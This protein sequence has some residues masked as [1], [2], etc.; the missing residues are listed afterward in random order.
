[1]TELETPTFVARHIG[2]DERQIAAMLEVVG[3]SSLEA[4]IDE[5]A[6]AAIRSARPLDLPPAVSEDRA[7]ATLRGLA[8]D[9]RVLTSMIGMGYYGTLTPSVILRNVVENPGWYTAYTP[10]QAEVSQGRLFLLLK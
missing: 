8:R 6:P 4:L 5:T 10:Y 9:N 1:L 3:A 2:P 7:L